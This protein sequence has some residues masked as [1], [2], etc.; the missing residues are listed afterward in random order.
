MPPLGLADDSADAIFDKLELHGALAAL[1]MVVDEGEA[2]EAIRE[3][4]GRLRVAQIRIVPAEKVL[5]WVLDDL[6]Y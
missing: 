5:G 4:L 3:T 1:L 2:L 6:S